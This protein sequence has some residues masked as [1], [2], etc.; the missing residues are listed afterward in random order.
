M[1]MC[2]KKSFKRVVFHTLDNLAKGKW[3]ITN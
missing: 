1:Q 2:F 3:V